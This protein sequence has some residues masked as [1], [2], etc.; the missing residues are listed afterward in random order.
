MSKMRMGSHI[1]INSYVMKTTPNMEI[2]QKH[3]VW[4]SYFYKSI[5]LTTWPKD[6]QML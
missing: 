6:H 3:S 5:L 2:K 4:L 1:S